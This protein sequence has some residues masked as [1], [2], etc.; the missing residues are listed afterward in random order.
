MAALSRPPRP[1]G[2]FA[3]FETGRDSGMA[4]DARPS[5]LKLY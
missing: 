3:S 2:W 1:D 4:A 5:N